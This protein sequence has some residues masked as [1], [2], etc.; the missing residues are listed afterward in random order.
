MSKNPMKHGYEQPDNISYF[1]AP[2]TISEY[3][4]V[5]YSRDIWSAGCI[6]LRLL[7]QT[8]KQL[9]T[10]KDK[11]IREKTEKFP[12]IGIEACYTLD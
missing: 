7:Y 9:E 11:V 1:Q 10:E 12:E 6:F 4:D 5:D 2:E 8:G 3:C